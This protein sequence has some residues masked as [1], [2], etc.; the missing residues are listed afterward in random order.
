MDVV[1]ATTSGRVRGRI[2][3]GI[4]AFRGIPY[5]A[6]PFGE[7]RFRAPVPAQ[8]W[9][10]VRDALAFGATAPK[11]PYAPPLDRLL[12]DPSIPGE[13]CLNLNV[14][15]PN[16][17]PVRLPVL[18][19][20]HGGSFRNG[21]SSL[22]IYDGRAFARDGVVL[23]SI[24]YRLGIEGFGVF[25]D[26]PNNRGLLD[27]I[28]ALH[29]IHDNIGA[30]GGDPGNVTVCGE[31]AGAI[32]IGALLASPR[33]TG[34]FRRAVLQS[35]PPMAM[36][37]STGRRTTTLIA[38]RLGVPATAQAFA[39]ADREAL[40]EAQSAVTRAGN[41][42]T[43]ANSFGPVIDGDLI[44]AD[45]MMALCGGAA[46]DIDLLLGYNSEEY[47]LWFVPTGVVDRVNVFTLRLAL[48]KFR[49]KARVAKQYRRS[50]PAA[51]PGEILGMIA[52]DM[53]IRAPA[54][55]LADSRQG[56]NT[57][58]YEFGWESPVDSLGA[59]HALEIAFV[60]DT[61]RDPDAI[62]LA[63]PGAPQHL[64]D[65]MHH[66]WVDFASTGKPGWTNWDSRRPVM[67]F[68]L[69]TPAVTYAPHDTEL[70]LWLPD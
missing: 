39:A 3:D 29:W 10:G 42:L 44:P 28:A 33:S 36:S 48:A 63:G 40:L 38:K 27:Q 50:N 20:I 68:D 69:P 61:L 17:N 9:D 13:E 19:W 37:D 59:C 18:V 49:I 32:S 54:N 43:G 60:F 31:S 51:K 4:A 1:V 2:E 22:P 70:R 58:L 52:T 8:P 11:R 34:L 35:G 14:W 64:A 46:R 56:T 26:A 47:R 62:A 45:P 21:S 67:R 66:S 24:N 30:F 16:P 65:A 53:L 6:A 5:A 7:H 41:P 23:V 15:T 57:F 25:P 12:P 55:R